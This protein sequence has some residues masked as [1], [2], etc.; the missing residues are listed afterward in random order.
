M[1][2]PSLDEILRL[3]RIGEDSF[4]GFTPPDA[5]APGPIY[6]G[7]LIAQAMLAAG[8]TV[9]ERPCNSLHAYFIRAGDPDSPVTYDVER[10]RDGAAFAT[11]R[12]SA[13]QNGK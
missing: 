4:H 12:V 6:G 1:T 8:G 9:D 3:E 13:H 11:R 5:F 10:L 7:Q 2:G